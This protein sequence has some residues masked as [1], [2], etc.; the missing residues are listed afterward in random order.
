MLSPDRSL[1]DCGVVNGTILLAQRRSAAHGD[2]AVP[3]FVKTLRPRPNALV[4]SSIKVGAR[5]SLGLPCVCCARACL[6]RV[7]VCWRVGDGWTIGCR[8]LSCAVRCASV[9]VCLGASFHVTRGWCL[10]AGGVLGAR[11]R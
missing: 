8:E 5:G 3:A 9:P 7:D 2:P 6:V 10:V 1:R 4:R 11:I